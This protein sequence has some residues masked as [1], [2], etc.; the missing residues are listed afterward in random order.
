[1]YRLYCAGRPIF[2]ASAASCV[3][4]RVP[5]SLAL[6]DASKRRD[7]DGA[8]YAQLPARPS[9]PHLET[10]QVALKILLLHYIQQVRTTFERWR[11]RRDGNRGGRRRTTTNA[12][13]QRRERSFFPPPPL[14]HQPPPSLTAPDTITSP[15]PTFTFV[16]DG[17]VPV[18]APADTEYYRRRS[19]TMGK[20][21]SPPSR[22]TSRPTTRVPASQPKPSRNATAPMRPEETRGREKGRSVGR[23]CGG[24]S[25]HRPGG[26][27][28]A[29]RPPGSA[30]NPANESTSS[31]HRT[32]RP[33]SARLPQP[34]EVPST[35][36]ELAY[37]PT[38]TNSSTI[39]PP[40]ASA[41]PHPES[42]PDELEG[43][44]ELDLDV[45]RVSMHEPWEGAEDE[46]GPRTPPTPCRNSRLSG[47]PPTPLDLGW[48]HPN[49]LSPIP[50]LP[51][52]PPPLRVTRA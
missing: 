29:T 30:S 48:T 9:E 2:L 28:Q 6:L 4:R 22:Y 39:S 33:G 1:M 32:S 24:T 38:A 36:H 52:P 50:V 7:R 42:T 49:S 35:V 43:L 11:R 14:L 13:V 12:R 41:K 25:A 31:F 27:K 16:D 10:A 46:K 18:S 21:P 15:T 5:P 34:P 20:H 26:G 8:S 37:P 3:Q 44:L 51:P 40:S 45:D 17:A 23:T 19:K 47:Y